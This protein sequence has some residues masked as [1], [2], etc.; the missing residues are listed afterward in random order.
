M[1]V[2]D[3]GFVSVVVGFAAVFCGCCFNICYPPQDVKF[4][5]R[6]KDDV[7]VGNTFDVTLRAQNTSRKLRTVHAVVTLKS[8][9]YT[10]VVHKS[11][12]KRQQF[13]FEVPGIR[14]RKLC[15]Y[16]CMCVCVCVCAI[17]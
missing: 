10:G 11:V 8:A 15:L 4:E 13:D 9:F 12:V 14:G 2:F 17:S 1:L 7:M 3:A 5:L 6:Q 16:L